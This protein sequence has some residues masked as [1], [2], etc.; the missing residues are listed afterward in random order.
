VDQLNAEIPTVVFS[1]TDG[2]GA[3][4]TAVK[5]SMDGE[6]LADQLD[7]TALAVDP[8]EHTF[9][10]EMAGQP[11]MTK[12]L[13]IAQGQKDRREL[14]TLG[15]PPPPSF[16]PPSPSAAPSPTTPTGPLS[17]PPPTDS[18]GLGTQKVLAIA[19]GGLGVV[20]L[21]IATAFGLM[22]ISQKNDAESVC[23]NMCQTQDGVNKW[24]D[25]S[26]SATVSTIGFIVGGVGIAGAAALWFTAPS[27]RQ[28]VQVG[29]G[30][31]GLDVRGVW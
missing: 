25:A 30:P 15:S 8:G 17:P 2:S 27:G 19:A 26:T 24:H 23:P 31:G 13:L 16:P 4:V 18:G 7:G 29:V 12:K 10:F 20:G 11:A 3:D 21:G 9:T 28:Q 1:V 5:I 6:K 22:A 14:V